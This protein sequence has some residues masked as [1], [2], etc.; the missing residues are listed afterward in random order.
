MVCSHP[1][2]RRA[3]KETTLVR[4]GSE[5]RPVGSAVGLIAFVILSWVSQAAHADDWPEYRGKGRQAVWTETGILNE[6][7]ADGL[8]FAW[9]VPINDGYAGPAVAGGRV[10]VLDA[11]PVDTI[12]MEMIERI[13]CLDEETG[14]TLWSHEWS[15]DYSELQPLYA[16]GPR[17]TPTVDGDRVYVQGANGQLVALDVGTGDVLWSKD[18]VAD[19]GTAVP[20]WGMTGA[21]LVEG[22]LL[23][24]LAGGEPDGKV[25]AF[26]KHTG[27]EVWRA[28]S[29]DWEPGYNSPIVFDVGGTTAAS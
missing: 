20:A 7:P 27:E 6:F 8:L 5:R 18:Y 28:L 4:W 16:I 14:E 3:G 21:P 17:A 15:A 24:C 19:F 25:I 11:R 1:H 10:F 9:R 26:D 29:S 2:C 12:G 23:I 22:D 13:L